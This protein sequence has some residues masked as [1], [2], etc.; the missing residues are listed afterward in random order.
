MLTATTHQS[1][2][3]FIPCH[4]PPFAQHT[5]SVPEPP[6]PS[7]QTSIVNKLTAESL[8]RIR[9]SPNQPPLMAQS[10]WAWGVTEAQFQ[11]SPRDPPD[12]AQSLR[13]NRIAWVPGSGYLSPPPIKIAWVRDSRCLFQVYSARH[14]SSE[15]VPRF[16]PTDIASTNHNPWPN[17]R[18]R[19]STA[20]LNARKIRMIALGI[21][22]NYRS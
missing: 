4:R 6:R 13:P 18:N 20:H 15:T 9:L 1:I 5:S 10:P 11:P 19:K 22:Q 8:L 12:K 21:M 16:H 3:I 2:R 7:L 17:A 14:E